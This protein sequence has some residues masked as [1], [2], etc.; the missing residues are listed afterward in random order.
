MAIGATAQAAAI[1]GV[2]VT[3][4][5][6]YS[7]DQSPVLLVNDSGLTGSGFSATHAEGGSSEDQW[8]SSGGVVND[9]FLTF[10]L[11]GTYDLAAIYIWQHNQTDLFGR[12]VNQFDLLFSTDGGSNY[13]LSSAN[14]N[15]AISAGGN[16]SAQSFA[17]FQ[18]GV[19]HVKIEIDSDWSGETSDFVGLAEV[20]FDGVA[21]VPEPSSAVLGGF[22]LLA[23]LRRRRD[24]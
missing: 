24:V 13:S 14:N 9:E 22:T 11:G 20:K 23:L 17:L 18:T 16:I 8:H 2:T 15:L 5:T 12:G 21:S 4:T 7:D 19:T 1:S 10:D 3:A 6:Y